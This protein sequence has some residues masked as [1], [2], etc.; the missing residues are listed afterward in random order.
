MCAVTATCANSGGNRLGAFLAARSKARRSGL[1]FNRQKQLRQR[2][3]KDGSNL[4]ER[5][6]TWILIAPFDA[7]KIGAINRRIERE[8]FL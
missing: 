4:V 1:S 7:P 8:L 5:I 3:A 6:D 2:N